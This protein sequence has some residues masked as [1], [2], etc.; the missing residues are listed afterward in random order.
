MNVSRIDEMIM[1]LEGLNS[2]ERQDIEELQLKKLNALLMRFKELPH[3]F[4]PDLPAHLESL[5]DLC[6][7]PFTTDEDLARNPGSF[8]TGSQSEIERVLSDAT[9]GTT[10]S[11]K[12]VF[13]TAKDLEKT[14]ELF[15]AGLGELVFPGSRTMICMPF[16]GPNGLG[17]LIAKAIEDLGAVPLKVGS[18]VNYSELACVLEREKPDTFVGFPTNLLSL[19]R[20]CGKGSLK[21][22]LVSADACPGSVT[23]ASEDILGTALFPHYGSREMALGGAICCQAHEGMHLRENHCIAE[24]VGENGEVLPRGEYGELVI[25]TIGMQAMPLIRYRTGDR[26]VIL[27]DPCPCGS[28]VLRLGADISRLNEDKAALADN[29]MFKFSSVID[30]SYKSEEHAILVDII[31]N[32]PIDKTAVISSL[33][34]VFPECEITL[35]LIGFSS[36]LYPLYKGK[37]VI[38]QE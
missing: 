16:S 4:Y 36:S 35:N 37:R 13:Y 31:H 15:K 10:G 17:D 14:V 38:M 2:L 9:S 27:K 11:Q 28:S 19:L 22:A 5:S 21:R 33:S 26:A 8:L 6:K 24:I 7:L 32:G 25:T 20:A 3:T 34:P 29:E 1:R 23:D 30:C 12:R 18:Y